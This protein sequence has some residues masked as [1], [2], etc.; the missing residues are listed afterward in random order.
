MSKQVRDTSA[1][2][3]VTLPVGAIA[4]AW[5]LLRPLPV[6]I[7]AD[8]DGWYVASDDVFQVYG[9]G[10]TLAN[11]QHDYVIS[12][13]DYYLLVERDALSGDVSA[14]CELDRVQAYIHPQTR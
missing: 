7:S 4:P 10:E 3:T 6:T 8:E 13:I 14:Q 1:R 9:D 12:L 11:A 5:E 2:D